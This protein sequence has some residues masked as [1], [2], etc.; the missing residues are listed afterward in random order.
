[1]NE[2]EFLVSDAFS[3]EPPF[4]RLYVMVV[5]FALKFCR[6]CGGDIDVDEQTC[7]LCNSRQ[8]PEKRF[9]STG[10]II[11]LVLLGFFGIML[12]GIMSAHAIQQISVFVPIQTIQPP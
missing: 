1:M 9:C 5:E 2:A 8:Q 4:E 11:V 12:L 10:L 3:M 6:I 7:G